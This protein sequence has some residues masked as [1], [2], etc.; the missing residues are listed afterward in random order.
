MSGKKPTLVIKFGGKVLRKV[1]WEDWSTDS[2]SKPASNPRKVSWTK[3]FFKLEKIKKTNCLNLATSPLSSSSPSALS[4][5]AGSSPSRTPTP[6]KTMKKKNTDRVNLPTSPSPSSPS[7][8]V[9]SASR[10]PSPE[11]TMKKAHDVH[12]PEFLKPFLSASES[13]EQNKAPVVKIK[14]TYPR[15]YNLPPY[16]QKP[17]QK[18]NFSIFSDEEKKRRREERQK[19]NEEKMKQLKMEEERR[20]AEKKEAERM[21]MQKMEAERQAKKKEGMHLLLGKEVPGIDYDDLCHKIDSRYSE[22]EADREYEKE[23]YE[24]EKAEEKRRAILQYEADCYGRTVANH[25]KNLKQFDEMQ[26]KKKEEEEC[27]KKEEEE[28]KQRVAEANRR[29]NMAS[30]SA[31]YDNLSDNY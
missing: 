16:L 3:N 23:L 10:T 22:W 15:V 19:A 1:P 6:E 24:R 28:R 8:N 20:E 31:D 26:T 30:P 2:R 29:W 25:L 14:R 11:K 17:N 9:S 5:S 7:S 12:F 21:K 18:Y 4:S 27:K 13:T